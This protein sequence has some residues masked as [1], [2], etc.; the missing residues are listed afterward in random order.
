[1]EQYVEMWDVCTMV[2]EGLNNSKQLSANTQKSYP[3]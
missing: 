3:E 1:M 2:S